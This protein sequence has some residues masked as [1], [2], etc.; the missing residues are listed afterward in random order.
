MCINPVLGMSGL[1]GNKYLH[2]FCAILG[3]STLSSLILFFM[4]FLSSRSS[5]SFLADEDRNTE[6][7]QTHKG[8][9]YTNACTYCMM[10]THK[11]RYSEIMRFLCVCVQVQHTVRKGRNVEIAQLLFIKLLSCN[12]VPILNISTI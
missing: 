7:L 8:G 1:K 4:D 5:S 12:T 2:R 9:I 11:F 6:L 3:S 10:Y